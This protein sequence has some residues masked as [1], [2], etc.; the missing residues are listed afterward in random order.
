VIA[1]ISKFIV[2]PYTLTLRSSAQVFSQGDLAPI[3]HDRFWAASSELVLV[4]RTTKS[5]FSVYPKRVN[6][7]PCWIW[8][9]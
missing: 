7:N 6:Q 3:C 8:L 1:N 4:Q 2:A 9:H 5:C